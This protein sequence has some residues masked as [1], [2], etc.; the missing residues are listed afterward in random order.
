MGEES[1]GVDD[2]C[3]W[4]NGIEIDFD[5]NIKRFEYGLWMAV[6]NFLHKKVTSIGEKNLLI[7]DMGG[8]EGCWSVL[9]INED[10]ND[11]GVVI[12]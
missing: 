5:G 2:E 10:D 8:D 11:G 1:G 7:F 4:V 12:K 9:M 6:W 3:E